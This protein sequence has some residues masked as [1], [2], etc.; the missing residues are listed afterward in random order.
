MRKETKEM[1]QSERHIQGDTEKRQRGYVL[2][3]EQR[4][5]EEYNRQPR[6]G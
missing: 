3:G 4:G 5:R 6:E 1:K 2:V